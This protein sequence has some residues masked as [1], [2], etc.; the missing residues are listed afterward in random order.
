MSTV[1]LTLKRTRIGDARTLPEEGC[2]NL[3]FRLNWRAPMRVGYNYYPISL[4]HERFS[5]SLM[6]SPIFLNGV[7]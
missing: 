4:A 2:E 7:L 1:V 6:R 3:A 5:F